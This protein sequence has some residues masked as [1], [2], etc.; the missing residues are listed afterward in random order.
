MI[1]NF[2]PGEYIRKMLFSDTESL[3]RTRKK[4]HGFISYEGYLD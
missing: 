3:D 2:T 4:A 1:V